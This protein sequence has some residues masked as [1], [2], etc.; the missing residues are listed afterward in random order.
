MHYAAK[1]PG[2]SLNQW[3]SITW[4]DMANP[5]SSGSSKAPEWPKGV[6]PGSTSPHLHLRVNSWRS[7]ISL[8]RDHASLE[9][10]LV[11]GR[12]EPAFLLYYPLLLC[13]AC[14][15]L[16]R[17]CHHLLLPYTVALQR[18]KKSYLFDNGLWDC[19]WSNLCIQVQQ[20]IQVT[21]SAIKQLIWKF[22]IHAYDC[23]L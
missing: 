19:V 3:L 12:G 10:S 6:E 11:V 17:Y 9:L 5:G 7:S 15:P 2:H 13:S 21:S 16:E 8:D 23:S 4:E 1:F 18:E 14:I 22:S 20:G